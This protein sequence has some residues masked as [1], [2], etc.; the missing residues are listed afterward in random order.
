MEDSATR[1]G[2][3]ASE[4]GLSGGGIA[5]IIIAIVV[6][7]AII[8]IVVIV[9]RRRK[10]GALRGANGVAGPNAAN[11]VQL[12]PVVDDDSN[13][14]VMPKALNDEFKPEWL[15]PYDQLTI[16]KKLGNG[17]FGVV[18]KGKW[19]TSP[20]AIKQSGNLNVDEETVDQFKKE[21]TLM[22]NLRPHPNCIQ[23]LGISNTENNFF[24]VMQLMKE[25]FDV[26]L[27]RGDMTL[28]EKLRAMKQA[29]AGLAHLHDAGIVHRDIAARNL[30]VGAKLDAQDAIKITD[31][32]MSRVLT[33]EEGS[34][35][36]K[37]NIGPIRWMAP[38]SI[39]KRQYSLKSDVFAFAATC[40]EILTE[41]PPFA[42][43]DMLE[44]AIGI[45]DGSLRHEIPE[46]APEWLKDLLKAC[47][48]MKPKD[49]PTMDEVV[50][51]FDENVQDGDTSPRGE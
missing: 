11:D 13:Y 47:F 7:A 12:A 37:S 21:A 39:S 51:A 23:V 46:D 50:K 44:V 36:T 35:S 22:L 14:G 38:E 6:V 1:T 29:A 49:R 40:V 5:G 27:K 3:T 45:R 10:S 19:K 28:A 34:G 20:V 2:P 9:A 41:R 16:Q 24:V 30:L 15:I 43:L 4:A 33:E 8:I 48:S 25:S 32:G 42:D 18:Y 31:F 26:T 17:A